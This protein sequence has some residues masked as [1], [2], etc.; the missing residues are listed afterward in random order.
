MNDEEKRKRDKNAETDASRWGWRRL[1]VGSAGRW[2]ACRCS[3]QNPLGWDWRW[4]E[5]HLPWSWLVTSA[6]FF[7]FKKEENGN[8][9]TSYIY[10]EQNILYKTWCIIST[11]FSS[12]TFFSPIVKWHFKN[13]KLHLYKLSMQW[14]SGRFPNCSSTFITVQQQEVTLF[15]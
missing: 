14:L 13:D 4:E 1:W 2:W 3:S 7:F 8:T 15:F 10:H 5:F 12:T 9:N 6:T 11:F